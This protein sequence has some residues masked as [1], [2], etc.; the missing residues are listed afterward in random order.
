VSCHP[1]GIFSCSKQGFVFLFAMNNLSF[2]PNNQ[3]KYHWDKLHFNRVPIIKIVKRNLNLVGILNS[4][5]IPFWNTVQ[6]NYEFSKGWPKMTLALVNRSCMG[7]FAKQAAIR[8]SYLR[9]SMNSG[10]EKMITVASLSC[11]ESEKW[12]VSLF[13]RATKLKFVPR[14]EVLGASHCI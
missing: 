12:G 14:A 2:A 10:V 6:I 13:S 11:D 9:W 8:C 3:L 4:L 1:L 5:R 7:L